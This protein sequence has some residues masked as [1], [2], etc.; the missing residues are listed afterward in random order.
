MKRYFS[1]L[2][3]I[4]LLLLA[5][6]GKVAAQSVTID[7]VVYS[8]SGDY[9]Y[10]SGNNG[11]SGDVV[12]LGSVTIE[13]VSY[14]VKKIGV[15]AFYNNNSLT[16]IVIPEGVTSIEAYAFKYCYY[17]L[18]ATLPE[19]LLSIGTEAFYDNYELKTINL[20]STV[21]YIG[22]M[23]FG[24]NWD[25]Q[26]TELPANL[27]TLKSAFRGC[28]N[29]TFSKI[30]A[31]V[32]SIPKWTFYECQSLTSIILPEGLTEIGEEAFYGC[33]NLKTVFNF[34]NL[35]LSIGG[36]SHGYVAYYAASVVDEMVDEFLFSTIDG[37]HYLLGYVGQDSVLNLPTSYKGEKYRISASAFSGC[38]NMVSISIPNSVVSIEDG[39]FDG[40]TSLPVEN[41][42]RYADCYAVEVVDKTLTNYTL[43]DNVRFLGSGLF[44]GCSFL[45]SMNIPESVI[46]IG[47]SAFLD[48]TSLTSLVLP[49]GITS[50]GGSAFYGCSALASIDI[51]EGVTSIEGSTFFGCTS[52]TSLVLPEGITS[53]GGSAFYGCS[54][55]ASIDI[56]EGVTS[57]EGSTFSG[58][59]SLTSL[60]LSEGIT[61][62]GGSAFYG[63]S[64]LTSLNIPSGVTSIGG[65]A[66][67]GCSALTAINIPSGMTSVESQTFWD[68]SSLTSVVLPEGVTSIGSYAF[69]GCSA[70]TSITLPLS[71]RG[72]DSQAFEACYNLRTII[73]FSNLLLSRGGYNHGQI[74]RYA[75]RIINVDE[76]IGDFYFFTDNGIHYLSG[77][78]G[79]DKVLVL[80]E[81]YKGENYTISS[82]AF[83]N[84]DS[85]TTITIPDFVPS[86]GDNAFENCIS[87]TSL[88]IPDGVVAIGHSAFYNCSS[89]TT[90][91]IP[92]KIVNIRNSTFYNCSSLKSLTIPRGVN[93]IGEYAFYNCSSLDS[94]N[95][96]HQ[97]TSIGQYAFAKCASLSSVTLPMELKTVEAYTFQDCTGLTS[98][99]LP[100]SLDKIRNR[101][102]NGCN[103]LREM[104]LPSTLTVLE[105]GAFSDC[106]SLE[107]LSLPKGITYIQ[108]YVLYNCPQLYTME[109]HSAITGVGRNNSFSL[110]EIISHSETPFNLSLNN[111]VIIYVPEGCY[112]AYKQRYYDNVVIDGKLNVVSVDIDVPGTLGEKILDYVDYL[113][114]VNSLSVSGNMND[115]D[116][117]CINSNLI[118]LVD[119]DLAKVDMEYVV[120]FGNKAI[121]NLVLPDNCKSVSGFGDR[122]NLRTLVLPEGL[123][124]IEGSC[125]R[126]CTRLDSVEMPEKL[127][128]IGDN[129][130]EGCN[131]LQHITIKDSLI[132]IGNNAFYQC[133]KLQ[134]VE[135]PAGLLSIGYQA[136]AF[137]GRL[138]R[139]DF[140]SCVASIG[141]SAF[142]SCGLK[143]LVASENL[144]EIGGDAFFSCSSLKKVAFG[145]RLTS[146][147]NRAFYNCSSLEDTQLG[148]KMTYMGGE[149]FRNCNSLS[150]IRIPHTITTIQ[151]N[152]F[153]GCESLV[154]IELHDSITSIGEAAFYGCRSL[155]SF[156]VPAFTTEISRECFGGC[157]SLANISIPNDVV[158]IGYHA[159]YDCDSLKLI[160]LPGA[161]R[162]CDK[163]IFASAN[164][165]EK[166]I[167]PAFFPPITNGDLIGNANN[168]TLYVPDWTIK[169]YKLANN[170]NL[171]NAIEPINGTCPSSISV[172]TN[173][174]LEIPSEG[175]AGDYKPNMDIACWNGSVGKLITHGETSLELSSF[176]MDQTRDANSMTSL[177]NYAD[178]TAD[179]VVTNLQTSRNTWH[180]LSFPYDVKVSEIETLGD[181]TISRY[182][183]QARANGDFNHTWVE[184]PYDS[185]LH[186]G[187]GYIWHSTSG[188]FSVPALDNANKNLIFAND[189]RYIQLKEYPSSNEADAGWNLIGNPYPC[190]YDSRFMSFTSPITVRSGNSYA[191]YSPLDDSY[192]LSPLEAFFVQCSG[193]NN[194][195]EFDA[196]GR[197]D[198]NVART[199]SA[200]VTAGA[201]SVKPRQVFNLYLSDENYTDHTRFVVNEAA[202]LKY[203]IIRDAAKFMSDDALLPQL[204]TVENKERLSINER[205]LADGEV[206]LGVYVGTKGSHTI[207]LETEGYIRSATLIDKYTGIE[208]DLLADSYT[209]DSEKGMFASRFVIRLQSSGGDGIEEEEKVKSSIVSVVGGIQVETSSATEVCLY[210]AVGR[211]LDAKSGTHVAFDVPTG[212]YVVRIGT[213]TYKVAVTK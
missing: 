145:E 149:A 178:L 33:T 185:M 11:V 79:N 141:G 65:S 73:N 67:S 135:F 182:D 188:A 63:C 131:R 3:A 7:G 196:E 199:L 195:I 103:G 114:E 119:L 116:K 184:I 41:G 205:P 5:G 126:N 97:V 170:W 50:I 186:V 23:A 36:T 108:D 53:I 70:L 167:C 83:Y 150:T 54:A 176:S 165:L 71:V 25:V 58:C 101:A 43:K 100:D 51:P 14:P 207:S 45:S 211:L 164:S 89:L 82:Y 20:P 110:G 94:I 130:F 117:A 80:P 66:F 52:L 123:E 133:H 194:L 98:V 105:E 12:I 32:T 203:E 113:R 10:V 19:G 159:F 128:I 206:N 161:L 22:E 31:G 107:Y 68:C 86:I 127:R 152:T 181:W 172:Y 44:Q 144:T 122:T 143:E 8:V 190:Y 87:L 28:H 37:I 15:N 4:L 99:Q 96:P 2:I 64:A 156:K 75:T 169:R 84:C 77:Y 9:A 208:T 16:S 125:F 197:Q 6:S 162:Y 183:G 148:T 47:G 189:A 177:M 46:S 193:D 17:N 129:A 174:S 153:N 78:I 55:L 39:A 40:C 137:C 155:S 62:I 175:L 24:Y 106:V 191:A 201:R 171:F 204:F 213:A 91:N 166:V 198:N 26:I 30:P 88:N 134:N 42:V 38:S 187:E 154:S 61:S 112:N 102:F 180:F 109:M 140:N 142:Y 179:S 48:C 57:I 72:I 13:G 76:Q 173:E 146:V 160:I 59:T 158:T 151:A 168:A 49:E 200:Y 202:S 93:S 124:H 74:A 132:K 120:G 111:S 18:S 118:N 212:V 192:I 139:V 92:S 21:E 35:E 81:N 121:R 115:A 90:V 210:N 163:E 29:V 56:P 209:F 1:S 34:S 85:L 95:I 104:K 60:V 157:T 138:Q 69:Y 147:G 136:F 27:K